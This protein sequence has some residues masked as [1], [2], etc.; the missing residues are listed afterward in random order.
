M[1]SHKVFIRWMIVQWIWG[2]GIG[3]VAG[4]LIAALGR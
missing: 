2:W 1:V 3:V 4:L